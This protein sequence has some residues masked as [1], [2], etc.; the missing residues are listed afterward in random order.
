MSLPTIAD[1]IKRAHDLTAVSDSPRL[2]V[3]VILAWVLKKDRTYLYTWPEKT[4]SPSELIAFDDAFSQRQSGCPVAHITG[5]REFWSLPLYTD[6]STLIPRPDTEVLVE[7]ALEVFRGE[8]FPKESLR[9]LDLGTGTGA[10]AIAL[11]KE[12]PQAKVFAVDFSED[13]VELAKRN[14][15]RHGCSNLAI[16]HGSWFELVTGGF[17]CIVSN[18]PY[19]DSQD[20]LI[21]KGDVRFEPRTALIADNHGLADIQHIIEMASTYLKPHGWLG[22]EHGWTQGEAVRELLVKQGYR[23]VLTEKDYG[24]NDRVTSGL[25]PLS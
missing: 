5:E 10:V 16:V 15:H 12:L 23:D 9:I 11:A 2:D 24:G 18:P 8:P 25:R 1:C 6:T 4:I 13:A 17:D 3:E 22:L 20:P 7:Q 19:I 14:A 21:D